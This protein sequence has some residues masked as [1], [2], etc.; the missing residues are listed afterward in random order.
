MN[1]KEIEKS[2][3]ILDRKSANDIDKE[4]NS[5]IKVNYL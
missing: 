2:G 5:Y 3:C 4:E 1:K